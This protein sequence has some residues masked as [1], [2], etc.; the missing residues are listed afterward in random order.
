[1]ADKGNSAR[2]SGGPKNAPEENPYIEKLISINRVAKVVKGGKNMSFSALTAIG[3]G[4]GSVGLGFGKASEVAN[5][6]RKA[7]D[8]ARRAMKNYSSILIHGRTIPHE[9][10]GKCTGGRVLL[11]PAS[12]GTG[13]IA[14]GAVRPILE[15]LG[16]Q[17]ILTKSM[18]SA[19]PINVG[20][21]TIDA[22]DNLESIQ[23][24][25]K[26]RGIPVERLKR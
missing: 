26:R 18:G 6:I 20:K 4:N 13:V 25:A 2:P 17:D 12:P 16:V 15:A 9:I 7:N 23:M 22:L 19:N 8:N 24:V 5:A 3:D 14:G 11:K 10:I 21:A 1:M